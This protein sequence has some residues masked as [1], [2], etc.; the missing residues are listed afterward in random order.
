[1]AIF[2][3]QLVGWRLGIAPGF[4]TAQQDL[5]ANLMRLNLL[6]TLMFSLSGLV[7]AGL[8]ANQHF[9]LPAIAPSMYDIGTLFGVLI[10]APEKGYRSAR[11]PCQLLAWASKAWCMASDW[12]RAVPAGAGAGVISL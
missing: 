4:Y 7:I 6:A 5:V 9:L 11:S 12:G 10:L 3:D 8:Q 2:A 1:M